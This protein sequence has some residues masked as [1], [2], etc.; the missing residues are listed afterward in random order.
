MGGHGCIP[1]A[2]GH[3]GIELIQSWHAKHVKD[4]GQL[5]MVVLPQIKG[6][7][8]QHLGKNAPNRPDI[9]GLCDIS[10]TEHH[11]EG[12]DP[13]RTLMYYLNVSMISGAQYQQAV[14]YSVMKPVLVPEGLVVL[15]NK[16][17]QSH[18]PSSHNWH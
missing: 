7:A 13:A 8:R 9:Y 4:E 15:T 14:T 17:G 11:C 2:M 1:G 3:N 10:H 5:V 6:L 12:K 16:Q 18:R